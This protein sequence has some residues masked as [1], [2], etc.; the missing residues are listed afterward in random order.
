MDFWDEQEG[1]EFLRTELIPDE[2]EVAFTSE[3]VDEESDHL[4]EGDSP[5]D[6]VVGRPQAG[7][8]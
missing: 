4:V 3:A 2:V 8:A 7:H 5:L 6:D 1:G